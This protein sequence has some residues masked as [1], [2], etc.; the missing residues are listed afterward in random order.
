MVSTGNRRIRLQHIGFGS[1]VY[2]S[3]EL[4]ITHLIGIGGERHDA[5]VPCRRTRSDLAVGGIAI[6]DWHLQVEEYQ[7]ELSFLR[8]VNGLL[9]IASGSDVLVTE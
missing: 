8:H 1:S 7:V 9:S 3:L 2:L 6:H 4:R 5:G